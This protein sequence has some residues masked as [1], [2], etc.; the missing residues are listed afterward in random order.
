MRFFDLLNHIIEVV[1]NTMEAKLQ[2]L[3]YLP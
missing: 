2:G 1:S 3:G